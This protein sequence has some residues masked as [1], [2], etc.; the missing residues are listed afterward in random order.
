M[1]RENHDLHSN[2]NPAADG[3]GPLLQRDYWAVIRSC[4]FRPPALMEWVRRWFTH[5]PPREMAT[6]RSAGEQQVLE[7]GDELDIQ[8]PGAGRVG[9]RVVHRDANSVTMAT[10]KGH[11]IAGRITFGAYPNERGDVIFHIRSRSR[12]STLFHHL[13]YVIAGEP[14]Q[15]TT[16]TDFIDRLAHSVGEGVIGVIHE[17]TSEVSREREREDPPMSPT[18][19]ARGE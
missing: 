8:L 19:V 12:S 6:F 17:E 14:M 13:G 15:T 9:V 10:L 7:V 3:R 18:F 16:W 5:L 1:S 2:L 4:E 11:P